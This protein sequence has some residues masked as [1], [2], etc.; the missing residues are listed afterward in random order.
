MAKNDAQVQLLYHGY[1][2]TLSQSH[3]PPSR[4]VKWR[5]VA[6]GVGGPATLATADSPFQSPLVRRFFALKKSIPANPLIKIRFALIPKYL[7]RV[8]LLVILSQSQQLK[9]TLDN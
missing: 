5:R 3:M 6:A 1:S 4:Y 9:S 8:A 7:M 2:S